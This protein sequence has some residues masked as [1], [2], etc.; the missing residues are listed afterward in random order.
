M[1]YT[2]DTVAM[3][4]QIPRP[5]FFAE[6]G[7]ITAVNAPAQQRQIETGAAL[8]SLLITGQE[9][10]AQFHIGCLYLTLQICDLPQSASVTA[11][12]SC[13]LFVLEEEADQAELQSMALAAQALRG[14]LSNVMSIAQQ[15]FPMA[16]TD[17][18]P[19]TQGQIAR[20]NRGLYQMLRVVCNMSDA[21]R[22]SSE[23]SLRSEIR[24]ISALMQD[25]FDR[26][27]LI[28]E[29]TAITLRYTGLQETV[30][31]MVDAEKLERAISNILSNAI[32][33]TPKG[34]FIDARLT[35]R[36]RMLYLTVQDSGSGIPDPIRASLYHRYQ[37]IPGLEDG[38]FGLGLGMVMI[39]SAAA[40]HGGTVLTE[41][42][43]DFGLRLTMTIPIRMPS[44]PSVRTPMIHAD[45]AGE[46]DHLLLEFSDCMPPELYRHPPQA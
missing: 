22:Y 35:R 9:E 28:I 6:N 7:I 19:Q 5:A 1:E 41:H 21:Y 3:L 30:Y 11:I 20:I 27:A 8:Q 46:L 24:N 14:P 33:F 34:G 17:D 29:H 39:R 43:E 4:H 32:K 12:G 42:G 25:Y 18:S 10:Y 15:M 44:D 37:R 2:E 16:S 31:G 36:G 26:A 23:N 38:R 45:Y 13:H 40:A